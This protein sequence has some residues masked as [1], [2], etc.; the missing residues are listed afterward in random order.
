MSFRKYIPRARLY[1][2][3]PTLLRALIQLPFSRLKR[4]RVSHE[5]ENR[6][7]ELYGTKYA[8]TISSCRVGLFF[9]LQSLQLE[10]GSEVL[11]TPITIPDII[12]AIRAAG[13]KPVFVEMTQDAQN[14]DTEDLARKI[15]PHS[16]VLLITYLSGLVPD[17]ERI[18][19]IAASHKLTLLEDISQNW[20]ATFRGKKIGTYGKAAVGS[21]SLGKTLSALA[22]GI[23]LT[24]DTGVHEHVRAQSEK[25]TRPSK[26]MFL[27]HLIM[28]LKVSVATHPIV[29]SLLTIRVIRFLCKKNPEMISELQGG[30]DSVAEDAPY[31]ANP[32]I[33]RDELPKEAFTYFTDFQSR[34]VQTC[35]KK[36]TKETKKRR[37]LAEHLTNTLSE[38]ARAHIPATV[39]DSKDAIHWHYPI[40]VSGDCQAFQLFLLETGI[41]SGVYSLP[42]LSHETAFDEYAEDTPTAEKIQTHS[43]FLPIHPSFTNTQMER[44]AEA[45]NAYFEGTSAPSTGKEKYSLNKKTVIVTGAASGLGKALAIEMAREGAK[46]ILMDKDEAGLADTKAN[47]QKEDVYTYTCNFTDAEAIQESIQNI[48]DTHGTIDVLINCAAWD[49]EGLVDDIPVEQFKASYHVNFYAPLALIQACIPAMKKQQSGQIVNIV[50]CM[51]R[52]SYPG[53][54]AY[55]VAKASLNSLTESLRV[56]LAPF[57]INAMLVFPGPMAT[58][59]VK[60]TRS[61]GDMKFNIGKFVNTQ[62]PSR[63][64]QL[65]V[66]G[67]KKKKKVVRQLTPAELMVFANHFAPWLVDW[68]MAKVVVIPGAEKKRKSKS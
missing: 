63:V 20:D 14:I 10:E 45:V 1:I 25:L 12:N 18:V 55:C 7:A 4:G 35:L 28:H 59:L 67:L 15:T 8:H 62:P 24:N 43:V 58:N 65:I 57:N 60:N 64:A 17:M 37:A 2:S 31:Y 11:V 32:R 16:R 30:K 34:I 48:Q 49:V 5:F 66:K 6:M 27:T 9:V 39:K 40:V 22:G 38:K 68:V 13:L 47:I 19:S 41:D 52:R 50:T 56:E 51:A 46:L 3:L 44:I 61:H 36:H 26:K 33:I 29:F 42:L 21:F 54:S 23:V 53:K